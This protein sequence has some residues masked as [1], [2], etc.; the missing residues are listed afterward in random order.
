[1]S[2][3]ALNPPTTPVTVN[4]KRAMGTFVADCVVEE[5]HDD[6]WVITEHPV[7]QGS[8]IS[9]HVYKLP[10]TVTLT[11]LWAMA[12]SLNA[13]QS[14]DFLRQLYAKLLQ[15]QSSLPLQ[16][17][18]VYTGKR[19]Y[20]NMLL[21]N[22]LVMTDQ[23]TE[24]VLSIR[25]TCKEVL[26]ANAATTLSLNPKALSLPS[27]TMPSTPV[28]PVSLQPAPTFNANGIPG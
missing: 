14:Q 21:E 26:I 19:V 5:R 13:S 8:V 17:F 16:T 28:G 6:S 7:E 15:I 22:L 9:D 3:L 10:A 27:T 11:Y 12:S 2:A 24:N 4:F 25:A 23:K 20:L 18:S 1:M